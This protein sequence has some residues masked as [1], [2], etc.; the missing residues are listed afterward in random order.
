MGCNTNRIT[1][2]ESGKSLILVNAE[3]LILC[4]ISYWTFYNAKYSWVFFGKK[5]FIYKY[6]NRVLSLNSSSSYVC[7]NVNVIER[8]LEEGTI[9]PNT[10]A[11]LK[12]NMREKGKHEICY[13]LGAILCGSE[14]K[15]S[16]IEV[17]LCASTVCM[18]EKFL[19]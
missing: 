10:P 17:P 19:P 11:Y 6:A 16:H 4:V 9:S 12:N 5:P 13:S 15:G 2:Y 14:R 1:F 3:T 8:M 7:K 18:F